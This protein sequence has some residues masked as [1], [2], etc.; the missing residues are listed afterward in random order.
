MRLKIL[1]M[2]ATLILATT[3]ATAAAK[4]QPKTVYDSIRQGETD[5]FY[6]YI[7][8]SSFNVYL[9]WNNPSNSLTLTIYSPNGEHQ[10]F[11]DSSDGKVDGK[12]ILTIK[13][14]EQD[15]WYFRVYGE[16]VTGVQYYSFTVI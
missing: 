16:K 5:W 8:S 3:T 4:V 6:Q 14:A 15:I 9:I 10:T 2:V 13:N 11:W 7:S 1:V 12:I